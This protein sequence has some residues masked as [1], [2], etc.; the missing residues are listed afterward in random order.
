MSQAAKFGADDVFQSKSDAFL[1][2]FKGQPGTRLSRKIKLADL[3][4]QGAG[5]GL[6]MAPQSC[7]PLHG[8]LIKVPVVSVADIEEDEEL[9][10]TPLAL[11]LTAQNSEFGR[12]LY[13]KRTA[14][15]PEAVLESW[16]ALSLVLIHEYLKNEASPWF[17][18]LQCLPTSLNTLVFWDEHELA[19]LQGSAVTQKVGKKQTDEAFMS[20]LAPVIRSNP[21]AFRLPA[22]L[23][24]WDDIQ[25]RQKILELSHMAASLIMAYAFDI[26]KDDSE[27][28]PDEDGFVTDEEDEPTKAMIPMADMLNADADRNNVSRPSSLD[29]DRC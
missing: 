5:R 20:R 26:A 27:E 14:S 15:T 21:S 22:G 8:K 25:S 10:A 24:A 1:D 17:S 6:G 29:P 4:V 18:Y 16:D 7:S 23:S 12:S 13:D 11:V 2:W 3:R 28:E 19:E 9:F